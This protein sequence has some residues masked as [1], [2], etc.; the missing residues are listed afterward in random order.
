MAAVGLSTRAVRA[1]GRGGI[2]ILSQL[3]HP[4]AASSRCLPDFFLHPRLV[5][6]RHFVVREKLEVGFLGRAN[7]LQQNP[8]CSSSG[9]ICGAGDGRGEGA[10]E[11]GP[12]LQVL[13]SPSPRPGVRKMLFPPGKP[14]SPCRAEAV[15]RGAADARDEP[16]PGQAICRC[17]ICSLPGRAQTPFVAFLPYS[18]FISLIC[19]ALCIS[20]WADRCEV[21]L[22]KSIRSI[23]LN[24]SAGILT[25]QDRAFVL[26]YCQQIP[27]QMGSGF[28]RAI[29]TQPFPLRAVENFPISFQL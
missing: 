18:I 14:R 24:N 20:R 27:G 10:P 19:M 16:P 28:Q 4:L 29:S 3:L 21:S 15:C 5:F 26:C 23:H 22:L 13:T 12:A 1:G 25:S 7:L 11:P 6:D 2:S 8:K 17:G 9:G